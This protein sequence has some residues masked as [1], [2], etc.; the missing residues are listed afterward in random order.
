MK[1][2]FPKISPICDASRH[3]NRG[4]KMIIT[5]YK[6]DIKNNV[7]EIS[8]KLNNNNITAK[9]NIYN[10]NEVMI[11]Y[12]DG[13]KKIF[14]FINT[15]TN[16]LEIYNKKKAEK[17]KRTIENILNT[18]FEKLT[19]SKDDIKRID[20]QFSIKTKSI[21]ENKIIFRPK[22]KY[23]NDNS[24]YYITLTNNEIKCNSY[25]SF[26]Y[27]PRFDL[28]QIVFFISAIKGLIR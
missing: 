21:S 12:D 25:Y 27:R 7:S 10:K 13:G 23:L 8:E 11:C 15:L 1:F 24:K 3:K 26:S 18:K 9:P 17:I 28:R 6:A 4:V 2:Y 5:L 14:A 19:L 20:E 16:T 22:I